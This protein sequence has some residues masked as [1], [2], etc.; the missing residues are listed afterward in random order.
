MY[1]KLGKRLLDLGLALSALM[2]VGPILVLLALLIRIKLGSPI[3]FCQE[4]AGLHGRPF[5]LLKFRT[6]TDARD[7]EGRLLPDHQRITPL[8]RFLRS[9]SLDELPGLFN[10]LRGEM[11]LI[12]PRPLPVKYLSRYTPE[13][14]RRHEVKPGVAGLAALFGR[15]EQS[16]EDI[17]AH[18]VWY[19]DH[20]S[21]WLDLKIIFGVLIVV[22]KREGVDPSAEGL[23]PEFMGSPA[24]CVVESLVEDEPVPIRP[25]LRLSL[26]QE[27]ENISH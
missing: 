4:R 11:S 13:Q 22:I 6:M 1:L 25:A 16:W 21:F 15:S 10:V 24:L 2:F 23:V 17:L 3:L 7:S 19:V 5:W 27:R 18:D 9:T 14:N 20:M 8:G 12:G 26:L